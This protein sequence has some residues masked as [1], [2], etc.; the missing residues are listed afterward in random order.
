MIMNNPHP[1]PGVVDKVESKLDITS[2][3]AKLDITSD[4]HIKLDASNKCKPSQRTVAI[5]RLR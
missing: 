2:S 3:D 1:Y 5:S 4:A